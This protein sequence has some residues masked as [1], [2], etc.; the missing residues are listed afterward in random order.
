MNVELANVRYVQSSQSPQALLLKA[1]NKKSPKSHSNYKFFANYEDLDFMAKQRREGTDWYHIKKCAIGRKAEMEQEDID[2]DVFDLA[3][4]FMYL[5]GLMK[6]TIL[7]FGIRT[8]CSPQTM[9]KLLLYF[10]SAQCATCV[11]VWPDSV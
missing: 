1:L 7:Q 2:R 10:T 4:Q 6:V 9:E 8:A 11:D 5:S 3:R